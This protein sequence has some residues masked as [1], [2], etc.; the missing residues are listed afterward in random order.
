MKFEVGGFLNIYYAVQIAI[1]GIIDL[2]SGKKIYNKKKLFKTKLKYTYL[3]TKFN[4]DL[5]LLHLGLSI[6]NSI[7]T[8]Y[9][10]VSIQFLNIN[11]RFAYS[12]STSCIKPSV[13]PQVRWSEKHLETDA[14]S[15]T[16]LQQLD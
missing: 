15:F 5:H 8:Y 14:K 4:L 6:R 3:K 1:L 2:K 10:R 12:V 9:K 7:A 13:L 16:Q 11:D